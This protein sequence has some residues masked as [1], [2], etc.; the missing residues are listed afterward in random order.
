MIEVKVINITWEK[1][2]FN[3]TVIQQYSKDIDMGVYQI[4]GQHPAYGKDTLLYIGK[5]E[6]FSTR[7]QQRFEFTESCA[8]PTHIRLG[9]ITNSTT[10]DILNISSNEKRQIIDVS[11]KILIKSHAPAFNKQE[12][13][14][15]FPSDGINGQHY[16]ILNWD[17]YGCLLQEVSTIRLSYRFWSF[18]NPRL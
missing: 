13:S 16:I 4:Y 18:D 17:D 10:E 9:R 5:A 15:L 3:Q 2:E 8:S 7:L 6:K 14:G 12:N 11:E 1:I